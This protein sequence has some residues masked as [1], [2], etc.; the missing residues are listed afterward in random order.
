MHSRFLL[1]ASEPPVQIRCRK[2]T[3]R[4]PVTSKY[5][6]IYPRLIH[7]IEL[8]ALF[9]SCVRYGVSLRNGR[10]DPRFANVLRTE[11]HLIRRFEQKF[12]GHCFIGIFLRCSKKICTGGTDC[13]LHDA[14]RSNE[15]QNDRPIMNRNHTSKS[16]RD[17][18]AKRSNP[19]IHTI[20]RSGRPIDSGLFGSAVILVATERAGR[21]QQSRSAGKQA[22]A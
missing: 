12:I 21:F 6:H 22:Y 5:P 1:F 16:G 15:Y 11:A 14:C 20:D 10:H 2:I 3:G 4:F 8:L 7:G 13:A 17:A 9:P 18:G 19:G